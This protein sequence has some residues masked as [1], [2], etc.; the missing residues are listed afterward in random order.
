MGHRFLAQA[1]G[2]SRGYQVLE[3][4]P[5]GRRLESY[6]LWDEDVKATLA[7][8][9]ALDEDYV[10]EAPAKIWDA[11][12]AEYAKAATGP[13]A[14]FAAEIGAG[15][16]LG[17]TEMPRVV[18]PEGVGREAV[19]FPIDFPQQAH[20]PADMHDL[21]ADP[22]VR[23]DLRRED[24]QPNSSTPAQFAAKLATL[25][26]PEHQKEAL[27]AAVAQLSA[28]EKYEEL[29]APTAE[30]KQPELNEPALTEPET[31]VPAPAQTVP[32]Q[33]EVKQ[34]EVKQPTP[35]NAFMPGVTMPRA[36]TVPARRTAS[37]STHGVIN[38]TIEAA[39]K[40]TD[41]ER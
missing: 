6:E 25:H 5:V 4:T 11:A 10:N 24:Y 17:G 31:K 20:L 23:C 29:A 2:E 21:M 14:V 32:K 3:D 15:S 18:G 39:P 19:G 7:D 27:A 35:A 1:C 28:V 8:R 9:F 33:P 12:S 34:P 41:I 26:V 40:S 22:A 13:V 30:P 16:I 38:P 36:I 37:A